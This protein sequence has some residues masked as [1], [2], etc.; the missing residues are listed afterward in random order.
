MPHSSMHLIW[1]AGHLGVRLPASPPPLLRPHG[2]GKPWPCACAQG[3][4]KNYERASSLQTV[5]AV[6]TEHD[7][8][9]L[10]PAA[11]RWEHNESRIVTRK[12]TPLHACPSWFILT[13][14]PSILGLTTTKGNT[15]RG[16]HQQNQQRTCHERPQ[17]LRPRRNERTGRGM[18]R[19]HNHQEFLPGVTVD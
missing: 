10:G 18:G 4:I 19:I 11:S 16:G 5:R 8:E 1:V 6:Q 14:M 13:K 9:D 7:A 15:A 12:S 17:P 2:G 3:P